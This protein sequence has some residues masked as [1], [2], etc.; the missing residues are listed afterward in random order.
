M[1][2]TSLNHWMADA[3][4]YDIGVELPKKE[5]TTKAPFHEQVRILFGLDGPEP[6]EDT[7]KGGAA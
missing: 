7:L 1:I 5:P 6:D 2:P 4:C 3:E